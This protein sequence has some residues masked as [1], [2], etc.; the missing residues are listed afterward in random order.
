MSHRA[1]I[2]AWAQDKAEGLGKFV[3]LALADCHNGKTGLCNPSNRLLCRKTGLAERTVRE[4]LAALQEAGLIT[5]MMVPGAVCEFTLAMPEGAVIKAPTRRDTPARG[6]PHPGATCPPPRHVAPPTPA[7]GAGAY[8]EG[9]KKEP[10]IEPGRFARATPV[11]PPEQAEIPSLPPRELSPLDRYWREA[12]ALL[13]TIQ[14]IRGDRAAHTWAGKALKAMGKRPGRAMAVIRAAA[15]KPDA[16]V[17]YLQ[18]CLK[19]EEARLAADTAP[20]AAASFPDAVDGIRVEPVL[21]RCWDILGGDSRFPRLGHTV[22]GWLTAGLAPA[23]IYASLT[24]AAAKG[25][26]GFAG[27]ASLDRWVRACARQ[28]EDA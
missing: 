3:L 9:T 28:A 16:G 15:A 14:G 4:V 27:E 23:A 24:G 22:A 8:K 18:G 7:S 6:A 13:A 5:R 10:G 26:E 21:D 1:T 20:P 12:P 19:A 11:P 2:W 25:V 17:A